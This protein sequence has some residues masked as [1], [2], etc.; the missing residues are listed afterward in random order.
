MTEAETEREKQRDIHRDTRD[1]QETARASH[2]A[3]VGQAV[4]DSYSRLALGCEFME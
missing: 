4:T 1:T 2:C 3:L